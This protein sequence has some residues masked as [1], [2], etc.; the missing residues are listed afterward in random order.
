ME[1]YHFIDGKFLLITDIFSFLLPLQLLTQQS[2]NQHVILKSLTFYPYFTKLLPTCYHYNYKLAHYL[3]TTRKEACILGQ[4]YFLPLIYHII[5]T[6]YRNNYKYS[7][8]INNYTISIS[9]FGQIHL[10]PLFYHFTTNLL[11]CNYQLIIQY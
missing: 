1:N 7:S 9:F 10:L 8:C 3:L 6:F 5:N 11:P 2:G 4:Y